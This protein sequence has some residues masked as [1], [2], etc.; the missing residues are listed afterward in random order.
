MGKP[1]NT[2]KGQKVTKADKKEVDMSTNVRTTS[3]M[4]PSSAVDPQ[5]STNQAVALQ[6]ATSLLVDRSTNLNCRPPSI[7]T[8]GVV[9]H[10]TTSSEIDN[11]SIKTKDRN[12]PKFRSPAVALPGTTP[13]VLQ[14]RGTTSLS[15]DLPIKTKDRD[16]RSPIC[17]EKANKQANLANQAVAQGA[18]GSAIDLSIKTKEKDRDFRSKKEADKA[19]KRATKAPSAIN[20]LLIKTKDRDFRSPSK[21]RDSR[22]PIC[23]HKEANKQANSA[24]AEALLI[25]KDR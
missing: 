8:K 19:D 9:L 10:G 15:I 6:G 11:L 21:D 23:G 18:T 14:G 17:D 4:A 2:K 3:P 13:A 7:K 24:Q 25:P 12:F 1:K 20:N 5:G 16:F 22:S